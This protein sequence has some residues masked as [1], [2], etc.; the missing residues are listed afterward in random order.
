ML[1]LNS[2]KSKLH[3]HPDLRMAFRRVPTLPFHWKTTAT[4]V[5][6]PF[7]F[8][9]KPKSLADIAIVE[10]LV[11]GVPV[12][13]YVPTLNP[14]CG[15]LLWIHGGGF[16]TGHHAMNNRECITFARKFGLVVVSVGYRL[17]PKFP[18]PCALTD[19]FTVWRWMTDGAL[20]IDASKIIIAGQS[21]GGGLAATL[22]QK[23][24]D[25]GG[26]QPLAQLLYYPMLDDRTSTLE[27]RL[28]QHHKVWNGK[29]NYAA[30]RWYLGKYADYERLPDYASAS[31]C[32]SVAN[33]PP[34]WI[35][36]GDIDLF[37]TENQEY[38][39]RLV[40]AGIYCRFYLSPQAPH[41]F[42]VFAP[43]APPSREL[44]N[45][46]YAFIAKQLEH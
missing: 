5:N 8:F 40:D 37:Y 13:M 10:R 16:I 42:D 34:T 32:H 45:D 17:A 22:A 25:G 24:R 19:C 23:I 28:S 38:A 7:H 44:I 26:S 11:G 29:S 1:T 35:G 12:R 46:S 43:K 20:G 36:V 14:C 21:A 33:L 4:L 27:N 2:N 41:G 18:F 9:G 3:I 30:W 15:A 31:R 39:Q 6:K